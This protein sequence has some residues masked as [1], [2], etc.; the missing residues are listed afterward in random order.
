MAWRGELTNIFARAL[1]A[2]LAGAV[3][4][5]AIGLARHARANP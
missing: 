1:V 5:L 4:A 2:A 3:L